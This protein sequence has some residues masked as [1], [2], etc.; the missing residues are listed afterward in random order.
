MTRIN[1]R[2]TLINVSKDLFTIV[3]LYND[4]YDNYYLW[5]QIKKR[6]AKFQ[7]TYNNKQITRTKIIM[8][9]LAKNNN[10]RNDKNL[11]VYIIM[12]SSVYKYVCFFCLSFYLCLLSISFYIIIYIFVYS[13]A[14]LLF[15]LLWHLNPFRHNT[16]TNKR[17]VIFYGQRMIYFKGRGERS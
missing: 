13:R 16:I 5:W 12:Y 4:V 8:A 9:E 6:L 1:T 7:L 2:I 15:I 10:G 17:D 14:V 3:C 11:S